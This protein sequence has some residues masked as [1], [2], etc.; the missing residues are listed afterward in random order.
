[1]INIDGSYGEGGGQ[2]L[3]T[4][5]TLSAILQK[6]A[7][8]EN[9]RA[10][11]KKPGLATQHLISINAAN[12]VCQ[13]KVEGA[14]LKS[15]KLTFSP[16]EINGGNFTFIIPTAGSI[17]LLLQQIAPILIFGD[18]PSHLFLTGGTHVAWSPP[19][20]Y[21]RDVLI[22]ALNKI[23]VN[24]KISCKRF[25]F[26]PRGGGEVECDVNPAKEILPLNIL[27]RGDLEE[28]YVYQCVGNLPTHIIKR[29]KN[30]AHQFFKEKNLL[31]KVKDFKVEQ[32]SSYGPGNFFFILAKFENSICGFSS[33]GEIGKKAEI[34]A[35]E[36]LEEFYNFYNSEATIGK[37]LADQLIIYLA[38]AN[39]VSKFKTFPSS[40][41]FTNLWAV[42][43]FFK[44]E[45]NVEEKG[46]II[47]LTV[48]G[49]G[50]PSLRK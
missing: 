12:Q 8:I 27:D 30:T 20:D 4:A 31:Q 28:I 32:V 21:W 13:G 6:S 43:N 46:N 34:V 15:K 33:I 19:I 1:M 7:R 10:G 3:R 14:S 18:R 23:G 42:N 11:R 37:H 24:L 45:Y 22:P 26:Y 44:L 50:M 2:I 25:G 38:F 16:G 35:R 41:L 9:I 49:R 40:H 48:N 47:I 36:A 39:G 17:G 29:E 5:I